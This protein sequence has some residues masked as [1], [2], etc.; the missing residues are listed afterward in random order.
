MTTREKAA[1]EVMLRDFE[2]FARQDEEINGGDIDNAHAAQWLEENVPV[3]SCSDRQMEQIYN[4]RWWTFRKHVKTCPEGYIFTEFLPDVSWAGP[5]NAINSTAGFHVREARWLRHRD[6][7]VPDYLR[8]WL[9]GSGALYSYSCWIGAAVRDDAEAIGDVS[10]AVELLEPLVVF[11]RKT[12]AEHLHE[13]GLYWSIDDRDGMEYSISGNGLRPTLNSY[14]I[15]CAEAIVWIAEKCGREDLVREFTEKAKSIREKMDQMLWDSRDGFYKTLPVESISSPLLY[16]RPEDVPLEHNVLE[17]VGYIPWMFNIPDETHSC[18]FR[19][20]LSERC[21]K[22]PYGPTTADRSHPRYRFEH[23]HECLWNGPSWPLATSQTL[24]AAGRLLKRFPENGTFTKKDWTD[25]FSTYASCHWLTRDDGTRVP[26]ID[27]NLDPDTG[28]WLARSIL[29]SRGWPEYLG[30]YERG[31]DYNHSEFCDLVITGI[32][33]VTPRADDVL[34]LRPLA[35]GI[36]RY[37][38]YDLPYHGRRVDLEYDAEAEEPLTVWISGK[39]VYR[40]GASAPV[41]ISF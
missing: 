37:A 30:G 7:Y 39:E 11:Y 2:E 26:W 22:A 3:F 36:Q 8:F 4:F 24:V 41:H 40:G 20:L 15:S 18:A 5:Y 6:R 10:L 9:K 34:E 13:S 29:E 32:C 25:L 21:F 28:E 27:E 35:A 33:G 17:E 14:M 12:E 1:R 23:P 19:Y 31:K 16:R 38:L